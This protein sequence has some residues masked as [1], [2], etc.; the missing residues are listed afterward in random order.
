VSPVRYEMGFYI[1]EDDILHSHRRENPP[2][3]HI[4]VI[5]TTNNNGQFSLRPLRKSDQVS[6]R[7]CVER[8]P[9]VGGIQARRVTFSGASCCVT[10]VIGHRK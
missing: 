3:I 10:S 9:S 8:L 1:P 4:T 7:K 5:S 2:I 6:N